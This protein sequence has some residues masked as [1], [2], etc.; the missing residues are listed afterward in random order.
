MASYLHVMY[1]TCRVEY[2]FQVHAML[3]SQTIEDPAAATS[4]FLEKPRLDM[5]SRPL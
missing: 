5:T 3:S 4:C 1:G 2:W